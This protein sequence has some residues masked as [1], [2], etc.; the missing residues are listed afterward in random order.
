MSATGSPC[1]RRRD[2]RESTRPTDTPSAPPKAAF[3]VIS[4]MIV[5]PLNSVPS[6]VRK[7][8]D[9]AEWPGVWRALSSRPPARITS[10]SPGV[11]RPPDPPR[12]RR[13]A[14]RDEEL[15]ARLRPQRLREPRV[16]H[17]AMREQD[18]LEVRHG[19]AEVLQA[20]P[21]GGRRVRAGRARVDQRKGLA[22]H[23]GG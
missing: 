9:P 3:G 4:R 21:E 12:D 11:E 15:R 16:V 20:L 19:M 1:S 2:A 13:V 10:P 17:V 5:S 22:P 18:L 14:P 6:T 8:V 23:G 7:H